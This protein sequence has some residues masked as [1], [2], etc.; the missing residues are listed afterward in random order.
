[1]ANRPS[2]QHVAPPPLQ[3]LP[4][5]ALCPLLL[6]QVFYDGGFDEPVRGAILIFSEGFQAFA[7]FFVELY[8][9]VWWSP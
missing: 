9:K 4:S 8:S 7:C 3:V 1:M 2:G 5:L 6:V